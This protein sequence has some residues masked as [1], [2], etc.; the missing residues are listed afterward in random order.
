MSLLVLLNVLINVVGAK[1]A[2][3]ET[4][5]EAVF[6]HQLFNE[7][8]IETERFRRI[9]QCPHGSE[10]TRSTTL[11]SAD[12][13]EVSLLAGDVDGERANA[14]GIGT[15]AGFNGPEGIAFDFTTGDLVVSDP[16]NDAI[17]RVSIA[18]NAVTTISQAQLTLNHPQGL[19]VGPTSG[20]IFV[21]DSWNDRIVV[22][23]TDGSAAVVAG[24]S[25]P[26]DTNGD[27]GQATFRNPVGM[28]MDED[29][30]IYVSDQA[31][32]RI[33]KLVL[34]SIQALPSSTTVTT[35]A[36][37]GVDG[38]LNGNAATAQF[39][40]PAGIAVVGQ[41]SSL[42]VLI[43]VADS[44]NH[45][46]R[47]ISIT[48][49]GSIVSTFAGTGVVG[50]LDG[51]ALNQATF[52]TPMA[53]A[54]DQFENVYVADFG[55][56][57][58]RKIVRGQVVVT[59]A[60]GSGVLFGIGLQNGLGTVAKFDAPQGVVTSA[61]GLTAFV[62]DTGNS[63]IRSLLPVLPVVTA[64]PTSSPVE[65]TLAPS[66]APITSVPTSAPSQQPSSH[67]SPSPTSTPTTV[68][69][70]KPNHPTS[71]PTAAPN[72]PTSFPSASPTTTEPT[73]TPTLQ[74]AR[75]PTSAPTTTPSS[76]P[77]LFPTP[78]PTA[79]PSPLPTPTPSQIPT[80]T[81][82]DAPSPLSA[83]PTTSP[84]SSSPT[85]VPSSSL[86]SAQPT[87]VPTAPVFCVDGVSTATGQPCVCTEPECAMCSVSRVLAE[88][89]YRCT[90]DHAMLEA[91]SCVTVET[92]VN[93]GY[94]A[95]NRGRPTP[96]DLVC[97][98]VDQPDAFAKATEAIGFGPAFDCN[99]AKPQCSDT[100]D[101]SPLSQ[102]LNQFC[103][104]TCNVC[105]DAP[106]PTFAFPTQQ[107]SESTTVPPTVPPTALP[108]STPSTSTPT[109]PPT[110]APTPLCF[111]DSV[112]FV[113]ET[114]KLGF[115]FSSCVSAQAFCTTTFTPASLMSLLVAHCPAVCAF[116]IPAPTVSA[117][118]T[119]PTF[120]YAP[121]FTTPTTPP[122]TP[123]PTALPTT[124]PSSAPT[125]PPTLSSPTTSPSSL[126]TTSLP[127]SSPTTTL[128]S[129]SP[130]SSLPTMS[131][132][133][134]PT[135]FPT[136]STPTA[137]PT[138]VPTTSQPTESP[139]C[140]PDEVD[141]CTPDE[142]C[143]MSD[144]IQA[145]LRVGCKSTC[146]YI[147][148]APSAAPTQTPSTPPTG[149][150]SS[151]PTSSMPTH[152][153]STP[154][155]KLP[156]SS[157]PT[158]F[159]TTVPTTS[160]P[161]AAPSAVPTRFP[162]QSS[163]TSSPTAFPTAA[164]SCTAD[165]VDKCDPANCCQ[166]DPVVQS[167]VILNCAA[168]CCE[169]T[170]AP[171]TAPTVSPTIT[172][173]TFPTISPTSPT[174]SPTVSAPTMSPSTSPTTSTPTASPTKSPTSN[175]PTFAPTTSSPTLAP[176]VSPTSAPSCSADLLVGLCN[177]TQCCGDT[178]LIHTLLRANCASTC[179][180]VTC[181]PTA[182]PTTSP[183]TRFPTTLPTTTPTAFSSTVFSTTVSPSSVPTPTPT[184]LTCEQDEL[185]IVVAL[186]SGPEQLCI[187]CSNSECASD[188]VRT[189][190]CGVATIS[191]PD[192]GC[193]DTS[194]GQ[195]AV[196]VKNGFCAD[197]F[198]FMHAQCPKACGFCDGSNGY[199]CE[200]GAP[201][202]SSTS[203]PT[204]SPSQ[205]VTTQC[206]SNCGKVDNGGG[207]CLDDGTT[208]TSCNDAK[209][210]ASGT[211]QGAPFGRCLSSYGCK[212]KKFTT[213]SLI[214]LPCE[215]ADTHCQHCVRAPT[216]DT[217][218]QCR[219]GYYLHDKK[220]ILECPSH[221]T[222]VG[223]KRNRKCLEPFTCKN[224]NGVS[225]GVSTAC[226]CTTLNPT[227]KGA[228]ACH[229][230]EFEANAF[231][232]KCTKCTDSKFLN[233]STNECVDT[234]VGDDVVA[235]GVGAKGGSCR[236][237][238]VCNNK[239]DEAG[240]LCKCSKAIG[241]GSCLNCDW[242]LTGNV[243]LVCTNRLFLLDGA[244]VSS[245]GN[246]TKVGTSK[247]GRECI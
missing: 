146:C 243:C 100:D 214:G 3:F 193:V 225:D 43:Y 175:S 27:G 116:C 44:G 246:L 113:S 92:C 67:P 32:H 118:T 154:P 19:V 185:S 196:F 52:N 57:R 20:D 13:V 88:T 90:A 144:L 215:C 231:G 38:L 153:P 121:S 186:V 126:P 149:I 98:C 87:G 216:G 48:A 39:S 152:A 119:S 150:P 194:A 226:T 109:T 229:T 30:V 81:P 37:S 78:H 47:K 58:I 89:C 223:V 55:S 227:I 169:V 17:R 189:G 241:G 108:S 240:E 188:E 160:T 171:T 163:P 195:C 114:S 71:F 66:Q 1:N 91:T 122:T 147:T 123:T 242:R 165:L 34:G 164:P 115:I 174:A 86:P 200:P 207:T 217:C 161:S 4:V 56:H 157:K 139:T 94:A 179:C 218:R 145:L 85:G 238:F 28:G 181:S 244:C 93:L 132:S 46:I 51:D 176:T 209:I 97:S 177:E 206:D 130:T 137:H 54:A 204:P 23:R 24:G 197:S 80:R 41:S 59:I 208:C 42:P 234:C 128:P 148:C 199:Q 159:P 74:P 7:P 170:C 191:E 16:W 61:D 18:T 143:H 22:L 68:P 26:G 213:G 96:N 192:A 167:L 117:P 136:I 76:L 50:T 14:N 151:Q 10:L 166:D 155:T 33:R 110:S 31:N 101:G 134:R 77:T 142:C 180:D 69:T 125:T 158:A 36:G 140:A 95:I 9:T 35:V 73:A 219:D 173:T 178:V 131:P 224:G 105:V 5:D 135:V 83:A 107:P 29:S 183:N 82:S 222:S 141:I 156:S 162:T 129:Q 60:G 205:T 84:L 6:L 202:Q 198:V 65:S 112:V 211:D 104:A 168:T 53:V 49:T 245:C 239:Q 138:A 63:Q 172:P 182:S 120:S 11:A 237:P 2:S 232:E 106:A 70:A 228:P 210:L 15:E 212:A 25:F 233:Q 236:A 127:S 8:S 72:H 230:C 190:S 111:D 64:A 247:T 12:C 235:Y 45:L 79:S 187:P 40:S 203:A 21:A 103:R 221:L 102:L 201:P 99:A 133:A 75:V 184:Q 62:A 124:H 220:C